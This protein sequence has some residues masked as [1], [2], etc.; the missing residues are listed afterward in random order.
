M[1]FITLK[2]RREKASGDAI[3]K[4]KENRYRWLRLNKIGLPWINEELLKCI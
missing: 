2:G 1:A 4:R 3:Y